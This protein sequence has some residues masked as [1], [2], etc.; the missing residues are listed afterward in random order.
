MNPAALRHRYAAQ[1]GGAAV[2]FALLAILLFVFIF[3]V[4]EISR[5]MYVWSTMTQVT[6]RAARGAAMT[7][8]NAVALADMRRRA[9]FMSA[10]GGRL[11][12]AGDIREGDIR[13]EYLNFDA[14]TV[15]PDT[16]VPA[17]LAQNTLNCLTNPQGATC[18][19]FVRVRLC[20]RD[21]PGCTRVTYRPLA[22]LPGIHLLQVSMP[23]F[24]AMVPLQT[25][26]TP[27]ACS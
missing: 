14:S 1:R 22:P 21:S 15:I 27:G 12:L 10:P 8:P 17:C 25:M 26:G 11:P 19:R 7:S 4:I 2:E 6:S 16:S 20:Q 24:T 3:G 9:M 5:M 23:F 13:I 18:V